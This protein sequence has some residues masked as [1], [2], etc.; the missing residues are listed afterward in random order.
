M[1][2]YHPFAAK[3]RLPAE[4]GTEPRLH[5]SSST[6]AAQSLSDFQLQVQKGYED[7]AG[8]FEKLSPAEQAKCTQKQGFWW[9]GDTLII[10]DSQNLRKQCLHECHNCPYS[11]HL[12]VTKT[13]KL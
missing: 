6:A 2:N 1:Q 11:G 8:W 10:S 7:D 4:T 12:G 9:H 5:P 3:Q 13:Q